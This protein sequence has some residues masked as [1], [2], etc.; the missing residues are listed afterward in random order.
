[1]AH[2][3]AVGCSILRIHS[4]KE[5]LHNEAEIVRRIAEVPNGG[6]LLLSDPQRFMR[7]IQIEI[8]PEA[9]KECQPYYPAF[10]GS[11]GREHVYDAVSKSR[12]GN[13]VR[14]KVTGLFRKG[15][16]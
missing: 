4:Y 13:Q 15:Q 1:M 11:T 2:S 12:P 5:L 16:V 6:E 3:D 14:V 8:T 7:D 9:V 10:F